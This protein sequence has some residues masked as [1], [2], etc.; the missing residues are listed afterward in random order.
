M[1]SRDNTSF[2]T[3]ASLSRAGGRLLCIHNWAEWTVCL[4]NSELPEHTMLYFTT[5]KLIFNMIV[6]YDNFEQIAA[7]IEARFLSVNII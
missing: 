4:A 3:S 5:T 2:K 1:V 6:C 7:F